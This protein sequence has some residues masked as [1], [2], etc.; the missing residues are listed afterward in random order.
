MRTDFQQRFN[1]MLF[2]TSLLVMVGTTAR[3]IAKDID[4]AKDIY[5]ILKQQCLECH[6]PDEQESAFRVDT[7]LALLEG[8]D[9]GEPGVVPG[10]PEKSF[11][12]E[13]IRGDDPDFVMPP[14]GDP[15]SKDQ[16]ALL[17][18]W[19]KEGAVWPGQMNVKVKQEK[20]DHWS[21]Q[22]IV[23]HKPPQV[24]DNTVPVRNEIDAFLQQRLSQAGISPSAEA[25]ALTLIRR[26]SIVLTGLPPTADEATAFISAYTKDADKAYQQLVDRLMASPH[27]GERWAQH[28]LDVIRWAETNGSES[29]MYRKNAWIYRDYVIRA[30]NED[31]SYDQFILEQ[32]AGDTVGMGEATGFLVAGPHVPAATV[33]QQP[34]AQRQAKADR[35]DEIMQTIGASMMGVTIGC[36]RCHNHKFDP[37]SI[38]D[39]YSMTAVFQDVEFGG[40]FPE[41]KEDHPRRIRSKELWKELVKQRNIMRNNGSWKED[42]IAWEEVHFK[43]VETKSVRIL[44]QTN[45]VRIDELE[46]FGTKDRSKNLIHNSEKVQVDSPLELQNPR[47]DVSAINDGEYGTQVWASK[48]IPKENKKPWVQFTFDQPQQINRM[49]ISTNREDYFETEYLLGLNPRNFSDYRV[50]VQDKSGKWV[51]IAGTYAIKKV[52]EDNP[53]RAAALEEIQALILKLDEEG[54]RPSFVANFIRPAKIHVL[55]RGSPENLGD[56]VFPAAISELAGDL[57]LAENAKGTQRRTAFAQWLSASENPLTSRVLVNRLWHH[58]FGQGIVSTASDFG[59]A[60]ALPTHPELLDWLA[61]EFMEPKTEGAKP[62]SMKHLIRQMVMSHAFRQQSTPR[63]DCLAVDANATLLWRFP[64]KRV[65]AEVIRDSILLASGSLD[66]TIGGKSYR[67]HNIKKR[68]SQWEV[69]DNH[70]PDTW[71]RLIYQERMRRVDDRLFTAFDFPDCGQIRA[72]RPVSTTPLQ[73]LNLMNS[74]F[75]V[76]QSELIAKR[77]ASETDGSDAASLK[78]CFQL[79]LNRDPT[80]NELKAC[81]EVA[82]QQGLNIVCRAILNSNEFAFLP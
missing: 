77:A 9:Y 71:R 6:G 26:A 67:I 43:P 11:M 19:V 1:S 4:F 36:A 5:P 79:T 28:W 2:V 50:E 22:K 30:F 10:K 68:Y 82:K 64:P 49:R 57:H 40:R 75:V 31:K 15:L 56:E 47:G 16:I 58:I 74:D 32:L 20:S 3:A 25:D 14:E 73:A 61:A 60:G 34:E 70:G 76:E 63:S 72:K 39:Y 55:R 8:G 7:R 12:L 54:P 78:R 38:N 53:K 66:T 62:W 69:I 52:N 35:M 45:S 13:A 24:K 17:T 80:S 51:V 27:F 48:G 81:L 41:F 21:F 33:G 37:I 23:R 42:W 65:E 29:N 46:I 44:F 18:R 59:E